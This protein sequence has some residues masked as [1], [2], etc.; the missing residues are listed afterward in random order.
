[1]IHKKPKIKFNKPE[2]EEVKFFFTSGW[3]RILI[4]FLDLLF[5]YSI[6]LIFILMILAYTPNS[7][8]GS[9]LTKLNYSS[10]LNYLI[11]HWR[12]IFLWIYIWLIYYCYFVLLV[13]I[14]KG[15]TLF[16]WIFKVRIVNETTSLKTIKLKLWQL[17]RKELVILFVFPTFM[18]LL[19]TVL[20]SLPIEQNIFILIINILFRQ[21]LNNSNTTIKILSIFFSISFWIIFFMQFLY[22]L[23]TYWAKKRRTWQ[24][25]YGSIYVIN[26]KQEQ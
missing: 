5:L 18:L 25:S 6:N 20:I 14:S 3:K 4:R 12:V 10:S 7:S 1:M 23:S 21:N 17:L 2:I 13:K 11:D 22:L 16:G 15:W 24:D 19:T 8:L 26:F 9:E